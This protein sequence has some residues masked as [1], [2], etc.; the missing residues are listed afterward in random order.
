MAWVGGWKE[1]DPGK[2]RPE[3]EGLAGHPMGLCGA[4]GL[5]QARTVELLTLLLVWPV[6]TD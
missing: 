3:L 4:E 6:P 5:G 1:A 2:V